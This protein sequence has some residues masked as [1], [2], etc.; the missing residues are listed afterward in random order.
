M[1]ANLGVVVM[2]VRIVFLMSLVLADGPALSQSSPQPTSATPEAA[3][4]VEKSTVEAKAV[5]VKAPEVKATKD[6][7]ANWLKTCLADWDRE[8]HMSKGEWVTT[9]RR[10][11]SEREKFL[12]EDAAKA[13]RSRAS[14]NA[15]R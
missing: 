7:A 11:S 6:T 12:F 2:R 13:S 1:A 9:C 4:P 5:L 15:R 3:A 8:T 10:V 14:T